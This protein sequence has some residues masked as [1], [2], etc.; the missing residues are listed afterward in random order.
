MNWL[1]RLG[2]SLDQFRRV[3]R[4]DFKE[5]VLLI[6]A[7]VFESLD[8]LFEKRFVLSFLNG[9]HYKKQVP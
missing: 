2:G 8:N 1:E 3:L 9:L 6:P 4:E 5:S 7:P